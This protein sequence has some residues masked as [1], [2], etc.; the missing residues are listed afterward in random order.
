M[1]HKS[2]GAIRVKSLR[3]L[4]EPP[5]YDPTFAL[6]AAVF[7]QAHKDAARRDPKVAGP[8]QSWLEE[9]Q[10]AVRKEWK[11]GHHNPTRQQRL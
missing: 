9:M 1:T 3:D 8:A 4:V 11:R 2:P 5:A 10:E 7:R 6:L